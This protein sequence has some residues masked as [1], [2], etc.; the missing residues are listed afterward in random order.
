MNMSLN[1]MD[2]NVVMY[3]EITGEQKKKG[4]AEKMKKT[5]DKKNMREVMS[6]IKLK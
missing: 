4:K 2:M 3:P 6:D 5:E 1:Q